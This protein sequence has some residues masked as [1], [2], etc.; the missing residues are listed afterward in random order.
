MKK[1]WWLLFLSVAVS[2]LLICGIGEIFLRNRYGSNA[3]PQTIGG[4]LPPHLVTPDKTLGYTLTPGFVGKTIIPGHAAVEDRINRQ[5]LRDYDRE[6]PPGAKLIFTVGDSMTYGHGVRFEEIWPTVLENKI[7]ERSPD[8]YVVKAGVPGFSWPQI[9]KQYKKLTESTGQHP[10]VIVGFNVDAG[11]RLKKPYEARGGMIVK[12]TYS[13][14]VVLDGLVYEKQS[15][16]ETINRLDTFL[17]KRSYFFRW[18]NQKFFYAYHQ[19]KKRVTQVAPQK[20]LQA[21]SPTRPPSE[22]EHVQEAISN[23]NSTYEI[24]E[25]KNAKMLVLFIGLPNEST[26]E[27]D[28]YKKFLSEKGIYFLDLSKF[29]DTARWRFQAGG[30]W[31]GEGHRQVAEKV[32]EFIIQNG[33]LDLK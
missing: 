3:L 28:F 19:S 8:Y 7:R 31:N 16:Y 20:G 15:R 5:G 33:L 14:L 23:F 11:E 12:S 10:L 25:K 22:R 6:F 1:E 26:D 32:Y 24:A 17:R 29:E 18:F 9:Y 13:N 2:F 4:G 21:P 30:H 27:I